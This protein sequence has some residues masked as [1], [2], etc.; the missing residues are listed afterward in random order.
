MEA[1]LVCMAAALR[2][3]VGQVFI[4]AI[5]TDLM[6]TSALILGWTSGMLRMLCVI[7]MS[8]IENDEG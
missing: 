6:L 1:L 3:G 7:T 5:S 4:L 8:F 2:L